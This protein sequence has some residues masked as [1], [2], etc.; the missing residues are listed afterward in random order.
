MRKAKKTLASTD[1]TS[2][3]QAIIPPQLMRNVTHIEV[4][5]DDSQ[6][7]MVS[8]KALFNRALLP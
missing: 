7:T 8:E 4:E 3:Y 2:P 5:V 6:G 1:F